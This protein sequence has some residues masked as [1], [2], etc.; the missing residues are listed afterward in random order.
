MPARRHQPVIAVFDGALEMDEYRAFSA[1]GRIVFLGVSFHHWSE[2]GQNVRTLWVMGADPGYTI[3]NGVMENG[4]LVSNGEGVDAAGAFLERSVESYSRRRSYRFEMERSYDGGETWISGFAV[5]EARN[6]TNEVP[7]LPEALHPIVE[8]ARA[9]AGAAAVTAILEGFAD[10]EEIEGDA[11][12]ALRFSSR[13]MGPD[14]WR[15]VYW[16][17]GEGAIREE[18]VLLESSA[19]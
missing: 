19:Q 14:R 6:R 11:G 7:P 17:L 18:E 13:Y 1:D 5:I 2:D 12:A 16:V 8:Q 3:I 15:S 10:I 9:Q 4:R